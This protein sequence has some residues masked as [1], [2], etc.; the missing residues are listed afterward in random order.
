MLSA[1]PAV[2]DGADVNRLPIS[3]LSF[4][5]SNRTLK[6]EMGTYLPK[7]RHFPGSLGAECGHMTNSGAERQAEEA[8][9][10]SENNS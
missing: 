1:S 8:S 3:A 6:F 9:A 2:S 5:L 10:L 7:I 4:F